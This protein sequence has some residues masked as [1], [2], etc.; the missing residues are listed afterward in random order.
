MGSFFQDSLLENLPGTC[1]LDHQKQGEVTPQL[2]LR[3]LLQ[4]HL[5]LPL[6][7]SQ[8]VHGMEGQ[9]QELNKLALAEI[10]NVEIS[11]H[12][13]LHSI[14]NNYNYLYI[15]K[16]QKYVLSVRYKIRQIWVWKITEYTMH[17]TFLLG[18]QKT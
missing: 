3:H 15:S 6:G 18:T 5:D 17:T 11:K 7:L 1:F 16:S 9:I 14:I 10:D 4:Q 12:C 13:F 8:L 2:G